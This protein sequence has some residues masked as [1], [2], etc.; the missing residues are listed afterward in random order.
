MHKPNVTVAAVVR[1]N[2]H[3]LFVEEIDKHTGER[4]LN[5]PAGHLEAAETLAQAAERELFEETGL[6]LSPQALVGVY[7]LY[8]SNGVHYLRFCFYFESLALTDTMPRDPDILAAK[9]LTKEDAKNHHTRSELV[10]RCI[11]DSENRSLLPLNTIFDP[12]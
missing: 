9:W 8:A 11:E 6:R 1:C 7:N 3:Y 2:E 12:K 10:L 4:V 5:Q